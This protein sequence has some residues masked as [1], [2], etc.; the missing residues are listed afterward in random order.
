MFG[1]LGHR[2]G[3][4]G[5]TCDS[6]NITSGMIYIDLDSRDREAIYRAYDN[7]ASLIIS[8]KSISDPKIPIIKVN[9]IEETYF[10]LLNLLYGRPV[11]KVNF[12]G[13]YG[14]SK[15]ELIVRLLEVIFR[16]HF[17]KSIKGKIPEDF[18]YAL[19]SEKSHSIAEKFIYYILLCLSCNIT[20]IPLNYSDD[21]VSFQSI[22]GSRYDCNILID[23]ESMQDTAMFSIGAG[24]PLLIN[25]DNP[26]IFNIIGDQKENIAI[27][28]G[29]NKK[30]A[31]T[32]TS[33]EYGEITKFNYCLQRTFYSKS[34]AILEPFEV[35]LSIRG[36]G[37]NKIYAS[38]AAISC[39]LYY[40]ID[41]AC[42][43]EAMSQYDDNG[44]DFSIMKYDSFILIE[45]YCTTKRD[46]KEALEML[47]MLD[48]RN[49]YII[50]SDLS[51]HHK[52][53][54]KFLLD[55]ISEWSLSLNIKELIILSEEKSKNTSEN[56]KLLKN[57]RVRYFSQLSKAIS[58]SI[59][60][61]SDKDVL[62]ILGGDEVNSS[63]G[64]IEIM[65]S[66]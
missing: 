58:S 44:R 25:I 28:Y 37:I 43:K 50:T 52:E 27:T 33:I 11:D 10:T 59:E 53:S 36:L 13:V 7:G 55:L 57:T 62:L 6:S 9:D 12:I 41:L 61:L 42:I 29:L 48:Y 46:Y 22:L 34:G 18:T 2:L 51:F 65:L 8:N 45:S 21:L 60:D 20:I 14:G 19:V 17:S 54:G 3:N 56:P 23:E 24:K 16:N 39:A 32:A 15:G 30:A 4:K 49:L 5:M 40:D 63:Q 64:I 66:K 31:V 35:P 38:L 26:N 1:Y 47:Q